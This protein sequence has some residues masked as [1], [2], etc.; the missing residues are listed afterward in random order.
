[1]T[2]LE[3]LRKEINELRERVAVLEKRPIYHYHHH[4]NG[5]EPQKFWPQP[6][7]TITRGGN[8]P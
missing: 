5:I 6:P 8:Q 3:L 4:G 1:M 2:E 7:Y